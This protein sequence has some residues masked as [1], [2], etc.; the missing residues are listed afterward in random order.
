M[1]HIKHIPLPKDVNRK[2]LG[3]KVLLLVGRTGHV[4]DPKRAAPKR[5][6]IASSFGEVAHRGVIP[7]Q[8][9]VVRG[10]YR[11]AYSYSGKEVVDPT[12][13][14]T[15]YWKIGK[16]YKVSMGEEAFV[17]VCVQGF[18]CSPSIEAA[19]S[20]VKDGRILALVEYRGSVDHHRPSGVVH[21]PK[22]AAEEMRI[23]HTW[24]MTP[25]FKT[26]TRYNFGTR[27]VRRRFYTTY[28]TVKIPVT[29]KKDLHQ[30]VSQLRHLGGVKV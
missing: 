8:D 11:S 13:S 5:G 26:T 10:L 12:W 7:G 25:E 22:T 9:R 15:T 17:R 4:V 29:P 6:R 2:N 16:W 3:W 23:L 24:E 27:A 20:Y 18:H 28:Q 19:L 30:M 21:H 1:D 14:A